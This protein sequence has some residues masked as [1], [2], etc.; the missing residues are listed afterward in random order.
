[1]PELVETL[2]LELGGKEEPVLGVEVGAEKG[3]NFGLVKELYQLFGELAASNQKYRSPQAVLLS[4]VD[5]AGQQ[6]HIGDQMDITEFNMIFVHQLNAGLKLLQEH[7]SKEEG[8]FNEDEMK[9]GNSIKNIARNESILS[10]KAFFASHE[11]PDAGSEPIGPTSYFQ[12]SSVKSF[13]TV[14]EL[15]QASDKKEVE[16]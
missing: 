4:L 1:V 5:E 3:K 6:L 15:K 2:Q 13:K 12:R 10:K 14:E 11:S 7:S 9:E 8:D 16:Q